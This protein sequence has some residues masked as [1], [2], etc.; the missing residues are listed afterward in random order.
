MIPRIE[1]ELVRQRVLVMEYM[2]GV[3][4]DRVESRDGSRGSAWRHRSSDIVAT[5]MEL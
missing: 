4:I 5:V 3:R 1:Q 2:D